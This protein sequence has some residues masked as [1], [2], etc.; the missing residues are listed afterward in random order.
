M[1]NGGT[2]ALVVGGITVVY[3]GSLGFNN[4]LNNREDIDAACHSV[5][6]PDGAFGFTTYIEDYRNDRIYQSRWFSFKTM[7]DGYPYGKQDGLVDKISIK[8]LEKSSTFYRN[9]DYELHKKRFDKADKLLAE[10]KKRFK[11]YF[12]KEESK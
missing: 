9:S 3:L 5:T 1:K 11:E 2:I 4:L 8:T 10:T 12:E 6:K 7:T